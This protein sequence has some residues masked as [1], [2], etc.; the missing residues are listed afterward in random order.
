MA[1]RVLHNQY[2]VNQAASG[3]Y[4]SRHLEG[5]A[6]GPFALQPKLEE[7]DFC[8]SFHG[9]LGLHFLKAYLATASEAGVYVNFPLDFDAALKSA[10]Q[11]CAWRYV[12][13]HS[14]CKAV[15]MWT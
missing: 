4:G 13:R 7:W 1:E 10:G 12:P 3:G 6:A 9:P 8:C 14:G 5:G 15:A 2:R 11:S